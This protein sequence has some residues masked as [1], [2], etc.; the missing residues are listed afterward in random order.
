MV[1]YSEEYLYNDAMQEY[2]EVNG[3]AFIDLCKNYK[4]VGLDG[5]TD[6][7]DT[8]HLNSSGAKKVSDYIGEYL[9]ENYDLTDFRLVDNNIWEQALNQ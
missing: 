4:E 2:A 6:F 7:S 1:P 8:G 9:S 5:K 3:C